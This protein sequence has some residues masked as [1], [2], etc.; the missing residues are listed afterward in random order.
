MLIIER[1]KGYFT[2]G[3]GLL[4]FCMLIFVTACSESSGW[5]AGFGGVP[6]QQDG[7]PKVQSGTAPEG[8]GAVNYIPQGNF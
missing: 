4:A 7:P 8:S 5:G 6:L 2:F 3:M 1:M